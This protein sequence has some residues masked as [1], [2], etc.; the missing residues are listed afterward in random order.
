MSLSSYYSAQRTVPG[1]RSLREVSGS[2]NVGVGSFTHI[3]E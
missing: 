2:P 1:L 3:N